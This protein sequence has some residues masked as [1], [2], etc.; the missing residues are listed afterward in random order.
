MNMNLTLVMQAVA[1]FAFIL[2]TAKV[3]WPPL[4]RAIETRQRQIA[5]GLQAGE[6]GR[7]SLST[8]EKRIGAMLDEAKQKAAEIVAQGEKFRAE[9]VEAART[10][11]QAEKDRIV[12]SGRS[13]IEQELTRAKEQLRNQVADLAVAG[14]SR[15][16]K[17]EVDANAHADLLA[18]I[19]TEL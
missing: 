9:T 12:A 19:R 8:A 18:A 11:A 7:Q 1:F 5:E 10:E 17:R 15:I 4:I 14:A 3:V 2:F 6:Q 13:E 16:L